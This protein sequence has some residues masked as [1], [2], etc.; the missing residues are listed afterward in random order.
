MLLLISYSIEP[1]SIR[2][3]IVVLMFLFAS[4][5][6]SSANLICSEVFPT[7]SRTIVLFIMFVV[8]MMGG[9]VG[10]WFDNY[11]VA[12]VLMIVVGILGF[13]FCP[14]SENKTL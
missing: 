9:M 2:E 12:G 14:N 11:I 4:P 13:L 1:L 3:I 6:G 10:V 8:S 5:A 7:A